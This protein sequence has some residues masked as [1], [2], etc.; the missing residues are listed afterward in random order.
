MLRNVLIATVALMCGSSL[1]HAQSGPVSWGGGAY[2]PMMP[3][4]M[5]QPP[6]APPGYYGYPPPGPNVQPAQYPMAQPSP[7][8]PRHGPVYYYPPPQPMGYNNG[9]GVNYYPASNPVDF[10]APLTSGPP[11]P[12]KAGSKRAGWPVPTGPVNDDDFPADE[13]NGY[14]DIRRPA[15]PIPYHREPNEHAF[16]SIDYVGFFLR[17]MRLSGPTVT[18]GSVNDAAPGALGQPG[19]RI[20]FGQDP[21]DFGLMSG[22]RAQIGMFL[23]PNDTYSIEVGGFW[24]FR[25]SQSFGTASDANGNPSVSR[26]IFNVVNGSEGAFINALPGFVAGTLNVNMSSEIGGFELNARRHWYVQERL[27]ADALVGFRYLRLAEKFGVVENLN[28]IDPRF[29]TFNQVPIGPNATLTDADQFN[30]VNQ[31]FGPQ[32]GGRLTWEQKWINASAFAK[33]GL[34]VT[35]QITDI[36]GST[37]VTTAAGNQFSAPGG[38]LAL[39]SNIGHHSRTVFGIVPELGLN[40]GVEL[41]QCVRLNL[42]Y[43]LLMWNH[44]TRAASQFDRNINPALAPSTPGPVVLGGPSAPIYRFTDEFFWAHSFNVG[45]EFHY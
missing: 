43:S 1:V 29:V 35:R 30:T 7:Y 18:T 34:G 41:T 15:P 23:D 28:S 36:A 8:P 33:L 21:A 10:G 38:I 25:A 40:L 11:A 5:M 16:G 14:V 17:P 12:R 2:P 42:G 13:P 4:P 22:I 32:I 31:F 20:I 44:V 24:V 9:Y 6:M 19:T 26:P 37:T 27:H 3:S 45:L 39:P